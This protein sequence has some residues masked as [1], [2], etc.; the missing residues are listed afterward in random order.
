MSFT[1]RRVVF[2]ESKKNR[3]INIILWS[4]GTG[5]CVQVDK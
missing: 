2:L 4:F 3:Q 5:L 1:G